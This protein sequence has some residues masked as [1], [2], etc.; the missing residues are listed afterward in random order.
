MS[1]PGKSWHE[2]SELEQGSCGAGGAPAGGDEKGYA[3]GHRGHPG[4]G[5]EPRAVKCSRAPSRRNGANC[6]AQHAEAEAGFTNRRDERSRAPCASLNGY[7]ARRP[8]ESAKSEENYIWGVAGAGMKFNPNTAPAPDGHRESNKPLRGFV[9]ALQPP[10]CGGVR[11]GE[12]PERNAGGTAAQGTTT[13]P[14]TGTSRH[15]FP[16]RQG[17]RSTGCW[18][19][20]RFRTSL[21]VIVSG[22]ASREQLFTRWFS[23]PPEP[24]TARWG[25][26]GMMWR[27]ISFGDDHVSSAKYEREIIRVRWRSS[28][29]NGN[30]GRAGVR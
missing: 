15:A 2:I 22:S 7:R 21:Q 24:D 16:A 26:R 20:W 8:T 10:V 25:E 28:S 27:Q 6:G 4:R 29:R 13:P 14:T 12:E 23:T 3:P 17:A 11:Q 19:P 30:R 18:V 1:P 5:N 9:R